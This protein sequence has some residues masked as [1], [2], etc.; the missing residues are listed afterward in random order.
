[1]SDQRDLSVIFLVC[2][3]WE[4]EEKRMGRW[5]RLPRLRLPEGHKNTFQSDVYVQCIITGVLV[6]K[7]YS[8]VKTSQI[9]CFMQFIVCWLYLTGDVFEMLDS[10]YQNLNNGQSP[11]WWIHWILV[12]LFS[13]FYV[14]KKYS[15]T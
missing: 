1:M 14:E 3:I 4:W 2:G 7:E 13:L 6:T 15:L 5:A 8:Y 12:A 10:R 11:I 9:V